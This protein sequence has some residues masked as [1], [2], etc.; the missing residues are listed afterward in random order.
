CGCTFCY[1]CGMLWSSSHRC[2]RHFATGA[3]VVVPT[4]R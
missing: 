4:E 2:G 3:G 1:R